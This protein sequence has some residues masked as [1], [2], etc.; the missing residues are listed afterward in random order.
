LLRAHV[1]GKGQMYR[2]NH[3]KNCDVCICQNGFG[4]AGTPGGE[5][6]GFLVHD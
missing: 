1:R 2:R 6:Y 4:G 3:K 5:E